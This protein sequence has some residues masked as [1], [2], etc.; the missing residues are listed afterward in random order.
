MR[1]VPTVSEELERLDRAAEANARHRAVEVGPEVVRRPAGPMTATVH[2]FLHHVRAQGLTCVPEPLG[3]E[4]GVETLRVIGG[5][6]GGDGWAHQHTDAGLASAARLLRA[7]HDAGAGWTPPDDAVWGA[8]P[9]AGEDVVPCH[10]DPGPWN[11]VWRDGEAVGLIDW[12]YLHPAPRHDDVAYALQWFAPWRSD[13]MAL[14]WHHFPQVPDRG[15]RSRA[16]LAAYGDLPDLDVVD[17]VAARIRRTAD[18]VRALAER[19]EEP[20]RTWVAD[21]ALESY[22]REAVWVEQHRHLLD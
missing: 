14:Q 11:V 10:G 8:P 17:A 5:A 18:H 2:S 20:Q 19:G 12:D 6:S 21:G 7:V 1:S 15:A 16:F 4:D 22:E 3:V 13:E 9:V